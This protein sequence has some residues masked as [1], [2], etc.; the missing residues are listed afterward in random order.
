M[1]EDRKIRFLIA[2]LF[3][4]SSLFLGWV[5]NS[6]KEIKDLLPDI[7]I[8]SQGLASVIGV[9]T[10][11][12]IAV[13]AV[14]YIIGTI[15]YVLLRFGFSVRAKFWGG[16]SSHEIA[17]YGATRE[18]IWEKLGMRGDAS[19]NLD[20]FTGSTFDHDFLRK[21]HKGI[22]EWLARRWNAFSVAATST[23]GLLLSLLVGRVFLGI[24]LTVRWWLPVAILC[25]V[26]CRSAVLAWR[27]TM[28]MISFHAERENS[29]QED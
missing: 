25:A 6:P 26:F 21:K 15:T 23:T 2:P 1:D 12:G 17:L 5:H 18:L 22:H 13:F 19:P 8:G 4:M 27:D 20:F 10:G 14:G 29:P 28:G 7:G 9:L 16:S 3:F 24:C 11:A